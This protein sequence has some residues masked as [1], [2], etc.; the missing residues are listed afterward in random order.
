MTRIKQQINRSAG[1]HLRAVRRVRAGQP[2]LSEGTESAQH[3]LRIVQPVGLERINTERL[4]DIR[5]IQKFGEASQAAKC[6]PGFCG[7]DPQCSDRACPGHPL[8]SIASACEPDA[9]ESEKADL[10][11]QVLRW[12]FAA[13]AAICFAVIVAFFVGM[14]I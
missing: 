5:A 6:P 2:V 13:F 4:Q 12:G 3:I 7:F 10:D 11:M 8:N 9:E 14:H 1:Q